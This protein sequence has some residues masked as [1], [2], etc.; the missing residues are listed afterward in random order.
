[1]KKRNLLTLSFS[2]CLIL[3]VVPLISCAPKEVEVAPEVPEVAPTPAVPTGPVSWDEAADYIGATATVCGSVV[4]LDIEPHS[5]RHILKLGLAEDGFGVSI[6]AY[7]VKKDFP[8]LEDYVGKT[9][10]VNGEIGLSPLG[11]PEMDIRYPSQ[12]EVQE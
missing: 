1:M 5:G 8:P 10:C 11:G 3:L 2:I 4:K 12:I 7:Y 9:I 6:Q